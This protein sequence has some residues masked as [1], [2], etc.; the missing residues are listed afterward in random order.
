MSFS[1]FGIKYKLENDD[2]KDRVKELENELK[3]ANKIIADVN[4]EIADA[5]PA[6]DWKRM[7]AFSVERNAM[8]NKPCTIIGYILEEPVSVT[9]GETTTKDVVRE[10]TLYCN[11]ARHKALVAEF[12][13]YLKT[14]TPKK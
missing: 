10:W 3:S 13:E 2:L 8:N 6:I 14:K 11:A 9:E 12:R 4:G 5:E 1:L 7:N